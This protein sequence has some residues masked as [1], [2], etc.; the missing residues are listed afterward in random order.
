VQ[1]RIVCWL[2]DIPGL[3]LEIQRIVTNKSCDRSRFA[4]VKRRSVGM[5]PGE[6]Q[7]L[8]G[9]VKFTSACWVQTLAEEFRG[10]KWLPRKSACD[11]WSELTGRSVRPLVVPTSGKSRKDI[12]D[13]ACWN[14]VVRRVKYRE[15]ARETESRVI[16]RVGW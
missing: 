5:I 9:R 10:G 2:F 15:K 3:V 6:L 1:V 8:K 7:V 14:K 16:A 11:L 12:P 13:G 4:R